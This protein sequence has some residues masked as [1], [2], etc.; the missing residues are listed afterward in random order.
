VLKLSFDGNCCA[1]IIVA[2]VI[3]ICG[4]VYALVYPTAM[5]RS[6][7]CAVMTRENEHELANV[8]VEVLTVMNLLE[9]DAWKMGSTVLGGNQ[10]LHLLS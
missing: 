3:F 4:P 1:S 5:G 10:C 6:S 8:R 9:W 2:P 7:C